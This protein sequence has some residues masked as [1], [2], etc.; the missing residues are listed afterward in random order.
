ME[1]STRDGGEPATARHLDL[2]RRGEEAALARYMAGGYRLVA[3]NWRCGLGELDL[4]LARGAVLVFCEVK[5]RRGAAFGG[6]H[7][8]VT[9]QKR[10]KLERLAEAFLAA[11]RWPEGDV[12][13]DVASVSQDQAG[14]LSVH[15]FEGAF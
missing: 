5:T 6:G 9:W 10:M 2:G 15:L 8:A 11:V 13:F 7:E 4:V 1:R 3:R 14:H 12:R